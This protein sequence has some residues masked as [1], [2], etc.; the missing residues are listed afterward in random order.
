MART[1]ADMLVV[2]AEAADGSLEVMEAVDSVVAVVMEAAA[3][4]VEVEV[5]VRE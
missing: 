4:E 3:A 5:A 2:M 1:R